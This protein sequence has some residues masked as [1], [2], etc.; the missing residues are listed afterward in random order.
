MESRMALEEVKVK[1]GVDDE[2]V[3]AVRSVGERYK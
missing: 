2:T 1:E 3:E